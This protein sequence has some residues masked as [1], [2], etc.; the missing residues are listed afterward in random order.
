MFFW[1]SKFINSIHFISFIP[2]VNISKSVS[3]VGPKCWASKFFH[4]ASEKIFYLPSGQVEFF[5][6]IFCDLSAPVL[7]KIVTR[8][9]QATLKM[10]LF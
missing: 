8:D 10:L 4:W 9:D 6:G 5:C 2:S 7:P 3:D 1:K